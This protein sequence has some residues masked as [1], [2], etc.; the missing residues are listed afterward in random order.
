MRIVIDGIPNFKFGSC[1]L[2]FK[3]YQNFFWV[4]KNGFIDEKVCGLIKILAV[5]AYFID[6]SCILEKKNVKFDKVLTLKNNQ[7]IQ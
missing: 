7:P 1:F 5:W 4:S 2:I 3:L 6:F